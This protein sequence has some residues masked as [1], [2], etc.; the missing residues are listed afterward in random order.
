MWDHSTTTTTFV[1]KLLANDSRAWDRFREIYIP[2]IYA[3]AKE[4]SSNE[5]DA[6]QIT[7]RIVEKTTAGLATFERKKRHGLRNFVKTICFR[8][9]SNF[10]RQQKRDAKKL[11]S[12]LFDKRFSE[13]ELRRA[14]TIAKKRSRATEAS[15]NL[16]HLRHEQKLSIKEIAAKKGVKPDTVQTTIRRL[17]I[18]VQRV[19]NGK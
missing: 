3:L 1:Q 15:W 6:R 11:D 2:L 13:L 18:A 7:E 19:L 4:Y 10:H 16:F 17:V 12:K 8:Q 14:I 9:I 5:S